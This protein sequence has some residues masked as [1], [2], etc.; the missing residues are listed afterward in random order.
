MGQPP[1]VAIAQLSESPLTIILAPSP[2]AFTG[3][4]EQILLPRFSKEALS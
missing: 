2:E 4:I 3:G 1:T